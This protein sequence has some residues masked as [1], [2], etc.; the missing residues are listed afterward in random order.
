MGGVSTAIDKA[1]P[2]AFSV[3]TSTN[4]VMDSPHG[5]RTSGCSAFVDNS[6]LWRGRLAW[7]R[8]K[9]PRSRVLRARPRQF[10]LKIDWVEWLQF[11]VRVPHRALDD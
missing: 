10:S 11:Y 6:Q 7:Q 2:D 5:T 3:Q 8:V 9:V 1:E 4:N